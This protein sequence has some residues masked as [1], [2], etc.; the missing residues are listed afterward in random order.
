M[1]NLVQRLDLRVVEDA[2]G[3]FE[4]RPKLLVFKRSKRRFVEQ[5][6]EQIR[7]ANRRDESRR[8]FDLQT[9]ATRA[10]AVSLLSAV[11]VVSKYSRSFASTSCKSPY[12]SLCVNGGVKCETIVARAR[13]FARNASPMLLILYR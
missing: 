8:R 11:S 7:L 10:A 2:S 12:N 9:A 4:L 3:A 6:V 1:Q 13:R 5:I